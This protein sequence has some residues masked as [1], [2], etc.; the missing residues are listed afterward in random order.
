MNV[1][2]HTLVRTMHE[3]HVR[4]FRQTMGLTFPLSKAY[5]LNDYCEP[6][7]KATKLHKVAF[8]PPQVVKHMKGSAAVVTRVAFSVETRPVV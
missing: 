7:Q 6:P 5:V 8:Y 2:M 1:K 3:K 4:Y